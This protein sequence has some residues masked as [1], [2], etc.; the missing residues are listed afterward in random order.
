[1]KSR[2]KYDFSILFAQV[3][4]DLFWNVGKIK[5]GQQ[6]RENIGD[7]FLKSSFHVEIAFLDRTKKI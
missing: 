4:F 2:E 7:D 6:I 1:M 3:H 5:A